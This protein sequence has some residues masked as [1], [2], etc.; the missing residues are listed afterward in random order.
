MDKGCIIEKEIPFIFLSLFLGSCAAVFNKG[1]G[2]FA[3]YF[4]I[5]VFQYFVKRESTF[6]TLNIF[7]Y[8]FFFHFTIFL[9]ST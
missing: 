3:F 6:K 2:G 4:H 1:I 5:L 7:Y 8:Y 9:S